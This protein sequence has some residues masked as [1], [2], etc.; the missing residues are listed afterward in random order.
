MK[1]IGEEE[2]KDKTDGEGDCKKREG[3]DNR[4]R[5]SSWAGSERVK[6]IAPRVLQSEPVSGL[7]SCV[8]G[9]S[10]PGI[11]RPVASSTLLR[12]RSLMELPAISAR[13]RKSHS[14][15]V[16]GSQR[17]APRMRDVMFV[18]EVNTRSCRGRNGV[19]AGWK[20]SRSFVCTRG[21]HNFRDWRCRLYNSCSSAMRRQII[22]LAH[23]GS[24]CTEFH[25]SRWTC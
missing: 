11:P 3:N 13:S 23:L 5:A 10:L 18:T 21:I 16:A 15:Q 8:R 19:Y 1:T 4:Q 20:S 6:L 25:A 2:Q 12:Q 7:D 24:Q 14:S 9:C 22:V 17:R